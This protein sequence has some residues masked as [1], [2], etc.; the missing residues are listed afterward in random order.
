MKETTKF[1]HLIMIAVYIRII[2]A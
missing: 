2:R 1:M